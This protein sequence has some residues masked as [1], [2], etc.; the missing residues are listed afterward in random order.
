MMSAQ[1]EE[2]KKCDAMRIEL[3]D[4]N[5][6]HGFYITKFQPS[7][8][9]T[10]KEEVEKQKC[11]LLTLA[12]SSIN[13]DIEQLKADEHQINRKLMWFT[14]HDQ[15]I[16]RKTQEISN[17]EGYLCKVKPHL[18]TNSI[19]RTTGFLHL[20]EKDA[21]TP[22]RPDRKRCQKRLIKK[23]RMDT[24]YLHQVKEEL[25]CLKNSVISSIHHSKSESM[26]QRIQHGNKNR[27][28]E[29]R[30]YLEMRNLN[31]TREIYT[32][33]EPDHLP[34]FWYSIERLSKYDV[35]LKRA[36]QHKIKIRLDDI[37][38][39][40]MD[41]KGRKAIVKRLKADLELV[42]KRISCL[43]KELEDVYTKKSKAYQRCY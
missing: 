37:E 2:Y 15:Y 19:P 1:M 18:S 25:L 38:D 42:R 36:L 9:E 43:Q 26:A 4:G 40:K 7:L 13:K 29:M 23:G 16:Q 3:Q 30:I 32:A 24:D 5:H 41:L 11:Q 35:D 34:S 20:S 22:L 10:Q 6:I 31:E 17:L 8:D 21:Q 12:R 39:M 28:E 33:P 27:L 14:N